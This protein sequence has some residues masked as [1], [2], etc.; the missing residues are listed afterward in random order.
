MGAENGI[1]SLGA[2]DLRAAIARREVSCAEVMN[3]TLD[4]IE[5]VN[6]AVNAIVA[7]RPRDDLMGEA[8]A[9]DAALARGDATGPLHGFPLAVK[10]L[11]AVAGL[12]FTQGSPVFRDRIAP[13]DS[14]MA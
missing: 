8:Q 2:V 4:R 7:L 5:R 14:I 12:P 1:V 10:D 13:A 9:A 11:D 3:A 6:P